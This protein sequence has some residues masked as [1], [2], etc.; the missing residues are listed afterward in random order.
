MTYEQARSILMQL[1][2]MGKVYFA[3][4]P[5]L[6]DDTLVELLKSRKSKTIDLYNANLEL[7]R[8]IKR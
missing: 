1:A 2:K 7:V 4:R 8:T 3:A 6:G 5:H